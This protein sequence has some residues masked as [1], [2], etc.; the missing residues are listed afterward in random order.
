MVDD[1]GGT[2]D[3]E[4]VEATARPDGGVRLYY[5]F[6][7]GNSPAGALP[8]IIRSA[9]LEP[10]GAKM[11]EMVNC[12]IDRRNLWLAGAAVVGAGG[13]PPTH[14]LLARDGDGKYR[15]LAAD[16]PKG[17]WEARLVTFPG[18]ETA[19]AVDLAAGPSGD[20]LWLVVTDGG[21]ASLKAMPIDAAKLVAIARGKYF[22]APK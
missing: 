22:D 10:A 5:T 16:D 6:Q 18:A 14:V 15:L 3:D 4:L 2:N 20:H 19:T 8:R 13:G 12:R 9:D 1:P 17:K 7:G 21:A 11:L